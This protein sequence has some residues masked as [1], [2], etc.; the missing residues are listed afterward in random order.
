MRYASRQPGCCFRSASRLICRRGRQTPIL[1]CETKKAPE[2]RGHLLEPL[3]AR[4]GPDRAVGAGARCFQ[5]SEAETGKIAI[6]DGDTAALGQQAV[7]GS[8]QAAEQRAGGQEADGS[9]LGHV[10]PLSKA[11]ERL[12]VVSGETICIPDATYNGLVCMAAIVRC[13]AAK[14]TDLAFQNGIG[15]GNP[16]VLAFWGQAGGYFAWGCFRL[17]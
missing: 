13:I 4:H 11:A 6:A 16:A 17:F 2:T 1:G 12:R 10:C 8:H 3:R 5:A 7:D 15:R 14:L 9:S